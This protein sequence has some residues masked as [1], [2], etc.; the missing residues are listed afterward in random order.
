MML[1]I[2]IHAGD[3]LGVTEGRRVFARRMQPGLRPNAAMHWQ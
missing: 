1:L 2:A 3:M